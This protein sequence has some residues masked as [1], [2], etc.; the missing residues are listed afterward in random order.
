MDRFEVPEDAIALT[1]ENRLLT[2][3]VEYL[4]GRV[5]ELED[6][7]V[8]PEQASATLARRD[9]ELAR[10][11]EQVDTLGQARSD[12]RWL[13]ERLGG[14]PAGPLLRRFGGFTTLERRWLS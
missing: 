3:E 5:A 2:I 1:M 11:R 6:G 14:S 13:L 4:R 10:L 12:L 9:R 8:L 7:G